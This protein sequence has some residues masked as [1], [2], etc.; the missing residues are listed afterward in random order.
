[1]A[2]QITY[3]KPST[4][5]SIADCY[6]RITTLS[7]SDD[8]IIVTGLYYVNKSDRDTGK[9]SLD[10]FYHVINGISLQDNFTEDK[11]KLTGASLKKNCYI[12]LKTLPIFE[13]G[14]DV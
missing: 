11:L 3:N 9:Q 2:I 1:M 10:N 14:A 12:Y 8:H 7:Q 5:L 6:F 4:S 13:N